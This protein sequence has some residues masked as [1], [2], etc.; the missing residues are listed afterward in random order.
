MKFTEKLL[1]RKLWLAALAALALF[2]A[3][4]Y[5]EVATVV[6]AYLAVQAGV[7]GFASYTSSKSESE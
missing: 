3:G 7:D 1:S 4:A 2:A 6:V 5:S